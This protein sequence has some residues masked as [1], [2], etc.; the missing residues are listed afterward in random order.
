[1]GVYGAGEVCSTIALLLLL[2]SWICC[3]V[4]SKK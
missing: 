2:K 1:M 3:G 4:E